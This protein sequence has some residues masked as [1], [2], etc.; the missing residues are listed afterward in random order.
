MKL[1]MLAFGAHPDDVEISVGG[2]L[3]AEARKGRLTGVVDLTR[4]ELGTRG[5]PEIREKEADAASAILGLSMRLNLGMP[6][7]MFENNH[8]NRLKVIEIIRRYRPDVVITNAPHDRHPDHG[9]AARLVS[10]AC[11]LA[12]LHK[13]ETPA[14]AHGPWRPGIVYQY[15]QFYH[16]TPDLIYDI[17]EVHELKMQAIKAHKSQ[18]Y[19]PD[20]NEPET[21][22]ASRHFFDNLTARASE[23]GLQAGFS[24]GEPLKVMRPPGIK[25]IKSLF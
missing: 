23:Y 2:L 5:T 15:M 9:K 14:V 22:I 1:D 12:G 21:L 4:G 16:F 3:I 13:V 6:D 10:E 20:S 18:F 7:G 8:E 17:S 19:D 24:H 25:D 11:F